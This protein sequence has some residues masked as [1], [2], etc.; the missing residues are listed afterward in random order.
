MRKLQER[1]RGEKI[2]FMGHRFMG[3]SKAVVNIEVIWREL[4]IPAQVRMIKRKGV[5]RV[6]D[7]MSLGIS[8]LRNYRAQFNSVCRTMSPDQVITI[9]KE[10]IERLNQ[11]V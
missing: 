4:K 10:K 5:W 8:F 3:K 6:Y 9:I 7:A 1:Y 11:K 2:K